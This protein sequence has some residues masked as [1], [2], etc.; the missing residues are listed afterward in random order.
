MVS[1]L[2]TRRAVFGAMALAPVIIA[3]PAMSAMPS[4]LSK[5]RVEE[6]KYRATM[7]WFNA[8]PENLENDDPKAHDAAMERLHQATITI[9]RTPCETWDEFADAYAIACD[10]GNSLPN[11]TVIMKMYED[12]KRLKRA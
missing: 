2:H 5:F 6:A 10:D 8:L 11:E 1:T 9:D 4:G 7:A 12:V 3:V